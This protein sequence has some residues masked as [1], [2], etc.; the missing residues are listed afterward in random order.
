MMK[1]EIEVVRSLGAILKTGLCHIR[2]I[3]SLGL[4]EECQIEACHLHNLPKLIVD[5][6]L[7]LLDYYFNVERVSYLNS[8]K[9][10][11]TKLNADSMYKHHWQ[12]IENA[13]NSQ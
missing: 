4:A 9:D 10:E 7:E 13:L 1:N 8:L 12:I 5:F 6:K 2:Y 11:G 3:G